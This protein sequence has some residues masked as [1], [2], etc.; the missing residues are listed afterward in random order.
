MA[1]QAHR[2]EDVMFLERVYQACS[3]TADACS[4]QMWCRDEKI[5][6]IGDAVRDALARLN[7]ATAQKRKVLY[8]GG[9]PGTGKTMTVNRVLADL[10][11]SGDVEFIST[12][13]NCALGST[14]PKAI[15]STVLKDL[16]KVNRSSR[17]SASTPQLRLQNFISS[18]SKP[19][20][21]VLD[22]INNLPEQ[23][24]R[25]FLLWA[26]QH[27]MVLIGIGNVINFSEQS[28]SG[29]N[30]QGAEVATFRFEAY[31]RDQLF[32][33]M[34]GRLK[35]VFDDAKFEAMFE[36]NAVRIACGRVAQSGGDIRALFGIIRKA[37]EEKDCAKSR[38]TK[39]QSQS[40][41]S[42]TVPTLPPKDENSCE[43]REVA[44][45]SIAPPTKRLR[46]TDVNCVT[47][48]TM[49]AKSTERISTL[50]HHQQVILCTAHRLLK[51][52][53]KDFTIGRLLDFYDQCCRQ[54]LKLP[55]LSRADA[56]RMCQDLSS[57]SLLEITKAKGGRTTGC[58]RSRSGSD[59]TMS[60]TFVLRVNLEDLQQALIGKNDMLTSFLASDQPLSEQQDD[61]ESDAR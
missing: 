16:Q 35:S 40:S 39:S 9:S 57:N 38:S 56:L 8:V 20:I 5:K 19:I 58:K 49:G 28:I 53:K 42:T 43:P 13:I 37:A 44:D 48:S 32:A 11:K 50:P 45:T 7:D 55:P 31:E 51:V 14:T 46:M 52:E 29:L 25:P 59:I 34:T 12:F 54:I 60:D 1:D 2:D 33:I 36:E 23:Y 47:K 21:I 61:E 22:E 3:T 6:S 30:V 15:Y 4:Q 27:Q 10:R 26:T 41:S 18:S 17:K 24:L